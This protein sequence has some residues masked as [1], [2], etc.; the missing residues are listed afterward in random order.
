MNISNIIQVI[1]KLSIGQK[2]IRASN[3]Y[4]LLVCKSHM[5]PRQLLSTHN[6]LFTLNVDLFERHYMRPFPPYFHYS[7]I[8]CWFAPSFRGSV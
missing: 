2:K 6:F 4:V 7:F 3:T 1:L 8:L 5:L